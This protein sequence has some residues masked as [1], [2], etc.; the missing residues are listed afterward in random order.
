MDRLIAA[1]ESLVTKA[2][3]PRQEEDILVEA[4]RS[5]DSIAFE[6]LMVRNKR[7]VLAIAR[8]MTGSLADGEDV[9]EQST[10]AVALLLGISTSAVKSRRLRGRLALRDRLLAMR[11]APQQGRSLHA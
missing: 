10:I 4:A 9:E 1:N 11:A 2:S 7:L 6:A 5:D 3:T 8:H